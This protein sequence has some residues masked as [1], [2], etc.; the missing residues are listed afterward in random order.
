[1]SKKRIGVLTGGGDCPG[2]NPAIRGVVYQAEKLGYECIGITDGWKGMIEN[3]TTP[4]N[5]DIVKDII[6]QGGTILHSSRTNPYKH[7]NGVAGVQ[8]TFK[9]NNLHA[10]VAIGGEDTLG[11]AARLYKD[12]KLNVV[13]VPKTMDNDLSCTDFTFGFDTAATSSMIALQNLRDTAASHRRVVV[14]EVMGR[15]A[16][17]VALY[18]ALGAAA[19]YCALPERKIDVDDMLKK[20]KDAYAKRTY[21]LVVTSEAAELPSVGAGEIEQRD[22]FGHVVLGG[23]NVGEALAKLIEKKT[24][25][26]TRSAVIGHIQRGGAPTLYDR[27]LG[28]RVGAAAAQYVHEGNFGVMAGLAG[29]EIKPFPLDK[30]TGTLKTVSKEWLDLM[31]VFM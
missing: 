11:V 19:D 24:G 7:E 12:F 10:L 15:H 17:W 4:L 14:L 9:E 1:M 13:G 8:K 5:K 3:L 31:D 21:A 6:M 23:R 20:V 28:T 26:E 25:L 18:T 16:G 27:I 29:N 30:A 2:L 22:D